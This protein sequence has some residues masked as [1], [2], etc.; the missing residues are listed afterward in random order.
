M[1]GG[2]GGGDVG[3]HGIPT[4]SEQEVNIAYNG[5]QMRMWTR[6]IYNYLT[7]QDTRD[8]GIT[9]KDL[10]YN[11]GV[12]GTAARQVDLAT[13]TT[14]GRMISNTAP[15]GEFPP[16]YHECYANMCNPWPNKLPHATVVYSDFARGTETF[17]D[18]MQQQSR[19]QTLFTMTSSPAE[20][21]QLL[22]DFA[23][24]KIQVGAF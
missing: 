12:L 18:F 9:R 8:L 11:D 14:W 15:A 13:Y 23:N 21:A 22:N 17:A 16:K 20:K 19:N 4:T 3:V 1:L 6:M 24:D 10:K 7:D 5:F 2:E